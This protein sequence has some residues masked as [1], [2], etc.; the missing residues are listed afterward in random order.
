[1]AKAAAFCFH[2]MRRDAAKHALDRVSGPGIARLRARA[3][4][5]TRGVARKLLSIRDRRREGE[6]DVVLGVVACVKTAAHMILSAEGAPGELGRPSV[7]GV[8]VIATGTTDGPCGRLAYQMVM[9]QPSASFQ[10]IPPLMC[11]PCPR[12]FLGCSPTALRSTMRC[13]ALEP[14]RPLGRDGFPAAADSVHGR[15]HI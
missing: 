15:Q 4:W 13:K 12:P 5:P 2:K 6:G 11:D 7:Q 10:D 3:G 9:D 14:V 8:V 1:M